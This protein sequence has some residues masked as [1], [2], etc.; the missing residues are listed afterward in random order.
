MF[1]DGQ[2]QKYESLM[3]QTPSRKPRHSDKRTTGFKYTYSDMDCDYC[4]YCRKCKFGICPYIMES[5]DDLMED[6]AFIR[7]ISAAETCTN[8]HMQTLLHIKREGLDGICL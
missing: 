3:Q 5:L 7:A 2:L 4:L 6:D 8:G 1:T